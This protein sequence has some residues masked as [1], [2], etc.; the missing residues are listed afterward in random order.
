[1]P[2]SPPTTSALPQPPAPTIRVYQVVNHLLEVH[3][4]PASGAAV[5][6]TALTAL[7]TSPPHV[8]VSAGTA[9]VTGDQQFTSDQIAEIVWTLTQF[10]TVERVNLKGHRGLTR[11]DEASYAPP[12]LIESPI[13]AAPLP[14]TFH[15]SGAA[16]V[17]EG[18]LVVELIQA[19]KVV[20]RR[21]VTATAGA[22]DL[23]AF[24]TV[25]HT[26]A[27]GPKPI[28]LTVYAPSAENGAPQHEVNEQIAISRP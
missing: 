12:I 21:T 1:M 6:T 14:H 18:T 24:D 23:G 19:G 3:T 28:T 13:G 7:L 22:P 27:S 2:P 17:F 11:T 16:S 10:P 8:A 25:V 5:A 4:V 26:T 20:F 9:V 15:V